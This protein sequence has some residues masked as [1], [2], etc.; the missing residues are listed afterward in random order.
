[1]FLESFYTFLGQL[2]VFL[3]VLIVILFIIV[4][5]LGLIFAKKNEIKF[6]RFVLFVVDLLYSPF[7]T[8]AKA[9]KLDEH[10]IDSIAI[11]VRDDINK[12]KFKEIPADNPRTCCRL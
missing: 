12:E 4:L 1:M 5:I 8:I 10:L 7:K 3:A 9:L 6:P 11:K 2:V